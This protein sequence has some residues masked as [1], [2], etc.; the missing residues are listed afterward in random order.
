VTGGAVVDP[1]VVI[2]SIL[3]SYRNVGVEYQRRVTGDPGALT[4]VAQRRS[5][6]ASTV[7]GTA[8][9]VVDTAAGLHTAWDGAAYD[10]YATAL[11]GAA[12]ALRTARAS[13]DSALARFGQ[14]A[15]QLTNLARTASASAVNDFVTAARQLGESLVTAGKY[16][17]D[18]LGMTLAQLF[19]AESRYGAGALHW[20][21]GEPVAELDVLSRREVGSPPDNGVA[22]VLRIVS[23]TGQELVQSQVHLTVPGTAGRRDR[24]IVELACTAAPQQSEPVVGEFQRFVASFHVR[25]GATPEFVDTQGETL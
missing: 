3:A 2:D 6:Q 1:S 11:T 16:A 23:G 24:V 15:R 7:S 19:L 9:E 10:A 13:V 18:Q 20:I 17:A 8:R 12:T 14:Y 22:R 21:S 4:A 5:G 25:P